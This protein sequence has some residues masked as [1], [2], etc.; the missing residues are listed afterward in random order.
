VLLHRSGVAP[1]RDAHAFALVSLVIAVAVFASAPRDLAR[2][3]G[4]RESRKDA[5]AEPRAS[6]KPKR[7]VSVADAIRMVRVAGTGAI[8]SYSGA[9]SSNFAKFSPNGKQFVFLTKK[10]NLEQNTNEYSLLLVQTDEVFR[11]AKIRTLVSFASSS[12]REAIT[13]VTWLPDN[14]TILFL[15]EKRG[16]TRQLYSVEAVSGQV[17][18]LTDHPTDLLA[19]ATSAIGHDVVYVA[20]RPKMTLPSESIGRAGFRVSNELLSDLIAGHVRE[21]QADLDNATDLFVTHTG[22][23]I[24]RRIE[25][26]N[27]VDEEPVSVSPNGRYLIVETFV[28]QIPAA[29][30]DYRDDLL[31]SVIRQRLPSGTPTQVLRYALV[32]LKSE[33]SR[34]LLDSPLSYYGSEVQ[35]LPDSFSVVLSGV[36]LPLD[37]SDR[38]ERAVREK[39]PCV[40]EVKL[41]SL[42]VSRITDNDMALARQTETSRPLELK[43]RKGDP[44]SRGTEY[45]EKRDG[46]WKRVEIAL[47]NE[48][49]LVPEIVAE[50]DLNSPPRVVAI[51]RKADQ[52]T[53][54]LDLNPEFQGVRFGRVELVKW[55]DGSGNDVEGGLYLPPGYE[56]GRKYP[57]VIQTHGF[58]PHAFWIDGPFSTA[59]AAQPLAARGIVVLQVPDTHDWNLRD[60]PQ[61][62]PLMMTRFENAIDYLDA[63]GIIDR[64]RVGIVGFSQTCLYVK[65]LLTHSKYR[66]SAA[67]VA[68]GIDTG[69]FQYL[70]FANSS[71]Y[72][73]ALHEDLVGAAPFG[74]GLSLWL[75]RSPG[76]LLDRVQTPVL[77]QAIHP[78]S[79]LGEWEWFAGLTKLHKP[80]DLIYFPTG[81]HILQKPWER[82]ASQQGSVDWFCFWLK[83]EEDS[84]PAKLQQYGHWRRLR[85]LMNAPAR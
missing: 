18:K 8:D 35:W 11:A 77:I 23:H 50:Q 19:Y 51:D 46:V 61:E 34:V 85:G 3:Q 75:K 57:L 49:R 55:K 6:R 82:L 5:G 52:K 38:A 37:V 47:E 63:K 59:F 62:A 12:N 13:D 80:V 48:R 15:G 17:R 64:N 40:V 69:Y 41:P 39:N 81:Y 68:D 79:L 24:R 42:E 76:F 43:S 9:L 30:H 78:P 70:A 20:D 65:Y 60:T 29:W 26:E 31:Q 14:K 32:D 72:F 53:L 73:E 1:R 44:F 67:V 45:F 71:P 84:D 83:S 16:T 7:P 25:V 36:Y 74:D 28:P 66:I 54:L 10:G 58:D 27:R 4:L 33:R 56:P 2:G 22:S 21:K